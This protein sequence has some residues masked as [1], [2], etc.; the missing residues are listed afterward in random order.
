MMIVLRFTKSLG[1]NYAKKLTSNENALEASQK[2][3]WYFGKSTTSRY[4]IIKWVLRRK[5]YAWNGFYGGNWSLKEELE[6]M[7]GRF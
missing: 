3:M 5:A 6:E 1:N 2:I 4:W 7:K